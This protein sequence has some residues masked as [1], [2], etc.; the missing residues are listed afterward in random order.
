MMTTRADSSLLQRAAGFYVRKGMSVF[1][2]HTVSDGLCSCG[3]RVCRNPG[4][5]PIASLVPHGLSD[6]LCDERAVAEW[7]A[8]WHDA[9]IGVVTGQKSAVIILDIDHGHGGE[10]SFLDLEARY[11][12]VPPTW[13][14]LTGG[15]GMHLWFRMPDR[16]IRNSAGLL[17]PGLDVR[18]D[19]GYAV[20]PPSAHKS[21]HAYGWAEEWR[22][23][24]VDLAPLPAWL[25]EQM[26][27]AGVA[28]P[29]EANQP[30][31]YV[32]EHQR[33]NHLISLGGTLRR[34][35]CTYATIR[36]ALLS[37]NAERCRPMLDDEEVEKVAWSAVQYVPERAGSG[38]DAAVSR[39][40][41]RF[42]GGRS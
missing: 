27:S 38:Q 42:F 29:R 18:G 26:V 30:T 35:G 16:P 37:E 39:T 17:G 11:G 15:G 31:V 6:A 23:G 13:T 25:L 1:P 24:K 33:N 8:S 22:P 32:G 28:G 36:A 41:A 3:D 14:C 12:T 19:G 40:G 9:N 20:A 7:W 10:D 21:G 2:V 4:K 34:R 5:H